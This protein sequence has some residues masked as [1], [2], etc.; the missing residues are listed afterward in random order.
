MTELYVTHSLNPHK[1]VK[2][3]LT[4]RYFVVKGE[5][6]EHMWVLELGTTHPGKDI[7]LIP[8]RKA[9]RINVN[10]LD[11][12]IEGMIADLCAYI[13]WTP[14]VE[15]KRAP[16]VESTIPEDG[17]TNASIRSNVYITLK[18]RLPSAGIDVS[19]IKVILNNSVQDIDIT[20]S[21]EITGDPFEYQLFWKPPIR[22]EDTYD[23][24]ALDYDSYDV[25]NRNR[26]AI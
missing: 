21:V 23:S 7:D 18:D 20:D 11:Y 3:N 12:L 15:D 14:Y 5:K 19:S 16:Y 26:R 4:L 6:G 10:D 8:S 13:D 9:H 25:E 2:F 1:T 22:V 17:A 24:V